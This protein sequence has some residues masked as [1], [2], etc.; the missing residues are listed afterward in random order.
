MLDALR[1]G[2]IVSVQADAGEPFYPPEAIGLMAQSVLNGGACALRVANPENVRYLKEHF[3]DVPLIAIT[4]P[5]A[6]P[7][8][9]RQLVYITPGWEDITALHQA[10]ADIVALDATM[11]PRPDGVTLDEIVSQCRS[12]FPTLRLMADVATLE[13]GLNAARLGFDLIS[14]TLS[15]YTEETWRT[16]GKGPDFDLLARLVQQTA[17]P[18][19]LEGRIWEPADVTRAFDLGAFAVV[20]GSAITRPHL[21]TQRFCEA[22]PSQALTP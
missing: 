4:K 8:N 1:H 20:I 5:K 7:E 15:G 17:S 19:I 12:A 18:I 3:P 13:D 9:Y 10:G 22:I 2:V 21:I 16:A 11:R 14:T 6:I